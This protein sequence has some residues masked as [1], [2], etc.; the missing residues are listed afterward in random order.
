LVGAGSGKTAAF[1]LPMLERL[2]EHSLKVGIRALVLSPTRELALQTLK[3]GKELGKFTDLRLCL[4]VGGDSMEE[5]F[6]ALARNPDVVMATPGRL[7]HHLEEIGLTLASCELLV[8][9]ECDRLFEMGFAAEMRAIVNKVSHHRQTLL[10][11]ATLPAALAE[12]ARAGLKEPEL[13][14]LD[15]DHKVS[16]KLGMA[17]LTVRAEERDAA[18]LFLVQHVIAKGEQ[19]IVFV[20][21][22]HHVEYVHA[23][24][25]AVGCSACMLYGSMDPS[26]RKV[27]IGR[28]RARLSQYLVVTDLAA[29]GV[30]IP[31]LQHVINHNFPTKPKLFVHR[32]GRAARAGRTGTAYSLVSPEEMASMIDL[33]L[34][35]GMPLLNAPPPSPAGAAA[36]AAD[37][38]AA[39]RG[40]ERE[41]AEGTFFGR[42]PQSV[43]DDKLEL[44]QR[45]HREHDDI[46]SALTVLYPTPYT[47]HPYPTPLTTYPTL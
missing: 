5:Q 4:L 9:D 20:A 10:F 26:A 33:H 37:A 11:S 42:V 15:V 28:F 46:A 24:L 2:Q 19:A 45:L 1:V 14:R 38:A 41:G 34:F 7:L 44:V 18:L 43:M 27:A 47:L 21:T 29:R 16:D 30:D 39:A 3:V 36:P 13:V 6:A 22:K 32:V 25:S 17:F 31:L 35:L 40:E 8:F 12:F 23:L